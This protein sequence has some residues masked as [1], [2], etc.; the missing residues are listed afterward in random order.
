MTQKLY[1]VRKYV[2]ASSCQDAL[3]KSEKVK[4]DDCWIA[5][6]WKDKAGSKFVEAIGFNVKN[7]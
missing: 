6:E 4:P 2:M 7:E 1:I 3:R 5:D